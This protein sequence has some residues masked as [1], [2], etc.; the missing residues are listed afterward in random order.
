MLLTWTAPAWKRRVC[1]FQGGSKTASP[2]LVQTAPEEATD[3]VGVNVS[4]PT[5]EALQRSHKQM[6][7][8]WQYRLSSFRTSEQPP[9]PTCAKAG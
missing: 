1:H 7:R 5:G 9:E 2:N 8:G 3:S 6:P 4:L